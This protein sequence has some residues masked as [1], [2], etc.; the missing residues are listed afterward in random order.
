M[1][2]C[3][4]TGITRNRQIYKIRLTQLEFYLNDSQ[5][6]YSSLREFQMQ[7][8]LFNESMGNAYFYS[9]KGSLKFQ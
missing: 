3:E 1:I 5:Y 4:A 7:R 2:I 9:K 6:M 8:P